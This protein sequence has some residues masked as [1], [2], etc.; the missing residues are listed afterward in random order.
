[1]R[2]IRAGRRIINIERVT[3]IQ[4]NEGMLEVSFGSPEHTVRLF[5]E[6]ADAF[7]D[8]L[9]M[10]VEGPAVVSHLAGG[11]GSAGDPGDEDRR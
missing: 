1:M 5:H 6:E 9:D 3:D 7:L 11:V 4:V 10:E 2:L 8:W